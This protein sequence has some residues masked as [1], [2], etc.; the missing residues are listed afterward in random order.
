M[1]NASIWPYLL[2]LAEILSTREESKQL[3]QGLVPK[4]APNYAVKAI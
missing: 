3:H 1:E 2:H 4:A